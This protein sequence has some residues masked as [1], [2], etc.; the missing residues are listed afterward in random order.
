MP[1]VL[2]L[3]LAVE[4]ASLIVVATPAEPASRQIAISI[5]VQE[6]PKL[7]LKLE[8]DKLQIMAL[9]RLTVVA[10]GT[11]IG[12]AIGAAIGAAIGTTMIILD[13]VLQLVSAYLLQTPGHI[14]GVET[15]GRVV[16][17]L[18]ARDDRGEIGS[19]LDT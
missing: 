9:G 19:T 4:M 2:R 7:E 12:I 16:A 5:E 3:D 10:I 15:T 13:V 14:D 17:E 1:R 8:R 11:A 18:F 6:K